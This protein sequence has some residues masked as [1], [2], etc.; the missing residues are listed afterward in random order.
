MPEIPTGGPGIPALHA[1]SGAGYSEGFAANSHRY[2]P[3]GLLPAVKYL[4]DEL[5]M[6]VNARD[7]EGSTPLHHAASRGDNAMI[8]YLVS[9]GADVKAV[10][11]EG[12]TTVDMANGP[13]QRTQPYPETIK[14]LEGLGAKN[15]H[16]CVSC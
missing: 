13:V 4:V 14:L 16:K 3:S 12:Q 2:A 8:L 11:R 10:N 1:A 7:H 6:D 15:N 9:K 5:G